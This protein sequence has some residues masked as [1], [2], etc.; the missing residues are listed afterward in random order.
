LHVEKSIQ[1]VRSW[2]LPLE[3]IV[4]VWVNENWK[5]EIIPL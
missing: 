4:G 2:N 5:V 3:K 1:T